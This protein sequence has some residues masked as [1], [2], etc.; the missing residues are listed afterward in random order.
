LNTAGLP[1]SSA[2]WYSSG[3]VTSTSLD[4]PAFTPTNCSSKPGMKDP[5][6]NSNEW[7][8]AFPPSKASP[9]TNPSKSITTVSPFSAVPSSLTTNSA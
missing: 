7:F 3:N 5:V 8:S 1:A 6:P 4:S 9:S 2:A